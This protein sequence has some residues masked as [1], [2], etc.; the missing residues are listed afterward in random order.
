[1]PK[2]LALDKLFKAT[3]FTPLYIFSLNYNFL[4]VTRGR[5]IGTN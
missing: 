1:M 3:I 2:L 4:D 5:K